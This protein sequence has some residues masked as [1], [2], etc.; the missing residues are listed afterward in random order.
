MKE[1]EELKK[2]EKKLRTEMYENAEKAKS[3]QCLM[4]SR[5]GEECR[6]QGN[7]VC[8][9]VVNQKGLETDICLE[10]S[11][12]SRQCEL[13]EMTC[14]E[15]D[16]VCVEWEDYCKREE[17]VCYQANKTCIEYGPPICLKERN[18]EKSS[19]GFLGIGSSK[20]VD[21]GC[22]K[23]SD[24]G[25]CTLWEE[26]CQTEKE[27]VCVEKGRDCTTRESLCKKQERQ[28][29]QWAEEFDCLRF[30]VIPSGL[31]CKDEGYQD[32]CVATCAGA[33]RIRRTIGLVLQHS[34][35]L[36]TR[37]MTGDKKTTE[38]LAILTLTADNLKNM[39]LRI[40]KSRES[41]QLPNDIDLIDVI[42]NESTE[43]PQL[44]NDMDEGSGIESTEFF[45]LL[46]EGS[47]TEPNDVDDSNVDV[48][49]DLD[50]LK[51][52]LPLQVKQLSKIAVKNELAKHSADLFGKFLKSVEKWTEGG[53]F[54]KLS[55]TDIQIVVKFTSDLQNEIDVVRQAR[56]KQDVNVLFN[57]DDVS[58]AEL[59]ANSADEYLTTKTDK[60]KKASQVHLLSSRLI[61]SIE[62][63]ATTK[64]DIHDYNQTISYLLKCSKHLKK[65]REVW[66]EIKNFFV[67]V[68]QMGTMVRDNA[69]TVNDQKEILISFSADSKESA[70]R[71]VEMIMNN[72]RESTTRAYSLNVYIIEV[73]FFYRKIMQRGLLKKIRGLNFEKCYEENC[74]DNIR[75]FIL[76]EA[77]ATVKYIREQI[78]KVFILYLSFLL[79]S[80]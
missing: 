36:E 11:N 48:S 8:E 41:T 46:N 67:N 70:D 34:I 33:E 19:S 6:G 52:T 1:L 58:L 45:Q 15:Y 25:P 61:Q 40:D 60:I 53:K 66:G 38:L 42:M 23:W 30:K 39:S 9:N 57:A 12:T 56:N 50:L 5:D 22:D 10:R 32:A 13:Y 21:K 29:V 59:V 71:V 43:Y 78:R 77:E 69:K 79:N 63:L 51:R 31:V 74:V 55:E 80:F 76:A 18:I 37:G 24:S 14:L 47:G 17:L 27:L 54:A 73:S 68:K 2:E 64:I 16:D 65:L 26:V 75:Q 35:T 44:L 3:A 72:I 7:Q 20:Y 49:E 62:D 28:C 4:E